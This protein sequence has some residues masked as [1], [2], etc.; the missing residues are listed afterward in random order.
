MPPDFIGAK[1]WYSASEDG[2]R[3]FQPGQ[4][5]AEESTGE[6]AM[7]DL[8]FDA[9]GNPMLTWLNGS[10]LKF[11]RSFDQ[12]RTF[13]K[14]MSIGNGSCE[15]CQP[16][17]ILMNGILHI[18]YRSR[19]P[20]NDQ[21]NIRDIVMI[22]SDDGGRTF[23]PVTRISDAHWYL[24]ACPIAGPSMATHD[25][26]VYVSW[27]DGRLEPQ[28]IFRRGD[29]W[30]ASSTDGGKTFSP[31]I[32]IN[33]DQDLHHNLPAIAIGPGGRIHIAWEAQGTGRA[34]LYYTVS[35]DGGRTFAS[36][37]IIAD[38][39]DPVRGIPGKP[40]LLVDSLG[41]VTLSWLDRGGVRLAT[42]T[43]A[44]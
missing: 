30:F 12:G 22:H 13:S 33:I 5:I 4:L 10:E 37:Q 14:T 7:V 41:H 16:K 19:E 27:M 31:N 2:G 44:R 21:G 23:Q 11:A 29:I 17:S 38:N 42:W 43:D 35:D 1:I 20:G 26:N 3:T 39:T 24:P 9:E 36:P 15:C 18:A 6:V 32:R 40:A 8:V 25:G 34:F 28:G